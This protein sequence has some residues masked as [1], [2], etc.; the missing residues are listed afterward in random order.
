MC[1]QTWVADHVLSETQIYAVFCEWINVCH[2]FK[3]WHFHLCLWEGV[4]IFAIRGNWSDETFTL[5]RCNRLFQSLTAFANAGV[6]HSY[7]DHV[8]FELRTWLGCA[9]F[10]H[11]QHP[12][13][14]F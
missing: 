5:G 14:C 11:Q 4:I 13:V 9:E 3:K 8:A 7:T 6:C 1:F 12:G 10:Q 2:Y